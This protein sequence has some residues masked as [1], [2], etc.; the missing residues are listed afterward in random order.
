MKNSPG[1]LRKN[2][3]CWTGEVMYL[4]SSVKYASRV[5]LLGVFCFYWC[6]WCHISSFLT[7]KTSRVTFLISI[8]NAYFLH[9]VMF[10][11]VSFLFYLAPR[12]NAS[13]IG[14]EAFCRNMRTRSTCQLSNLDSLC[15][16]HEVTKACVHI[17]GAFL[18][19][20][21]FACFLI[22]ILFRTDTK[23]TCLIV[24]LAV[25]SSRMF[26]YGGVVQ[27]SF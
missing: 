26:P 2:V 16:T 15:L 12:M 21:P 10:S 8:A 6:I 18:W 7:F 19:T 27:W 17:I 13:S 5:V 14:C 1:K 3:L 9:L 24:F 11:F 25:F 22:P 4:Q 20:N 23:L